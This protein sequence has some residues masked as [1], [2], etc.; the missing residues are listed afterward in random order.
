MPYPPARGLTNGPAPIVLQPRGWVLW[1]ANGHQPVLLWETLRV[2][3]LGRGLSAVLES[4]RAPRAVHDPGKTAADLAAA[5][6]AVRAARAAAQERAW[7]AGRGCRAR[8]RRRPGHHRP[9]RHYRDRV[10]TWRRSRPPRPGR[11]PSACYPMTAWADHRHDGNGEPLTI[12]LWAGNA[13]SNTAPQ[14][15]TS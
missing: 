7:G 13:D 15:A 11:R 3:G 8:R 5:L 1:C 4:W 9:G 10:L 6:A 2:T 14:P 12:V